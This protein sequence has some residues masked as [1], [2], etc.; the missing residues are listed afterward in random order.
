MKKVQWNKTKEWL[1]QKNHV[2]F[3]EMIETLETLDLCFV[4]V[5]M[6]Q[7]V[8]TPIMKVLVLHQRQESTSSDDS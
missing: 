8:V 7:W 4:S 1:L 2:I 5:D 6:H 3:P